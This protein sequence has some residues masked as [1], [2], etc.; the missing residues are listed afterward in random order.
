MMWIDERVPVP[1][2]RHVIRIGTETGSGPL[3]C[4]R[5]GRP[6]GMTAFRKA[7]G[8][9]VSFWSHGRDSVHPAEVLA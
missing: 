4:T 5:C 7:D 8:S 3:R 1:P 9:L 2:K 6:V